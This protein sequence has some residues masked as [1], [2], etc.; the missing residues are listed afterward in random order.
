MPAVLAP[1]LT[2]GVLAVPSAAFAQNGPTGHSGCYRAKPS[3]T[4]DSFLQADN[5]TTKI[6]SSSNRVTVTA[7]ATGTAYDCGPAGRGKTVPKIYVELKFRAEGKRL[8]CGGTVG[9][10]ATGGTGGG[11]SVNGSITCNGERTEMEV[12]LKHTCKTAE[13]C[14]I[15]VTDETFSA[16]SDGRIS[17]LETRAIVT[18]GSN[19]RTSSFVSLFD[20]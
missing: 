18:N 14:R 11:P 17:M 6:R 19:V 5:S 2:V 8:A 15:S 16:A 12:T 1:V 20:E 4:Y 7:I 3:D 9:G 13:R 10:G